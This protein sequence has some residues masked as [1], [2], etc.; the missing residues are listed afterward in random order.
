MRT[1]IFVLG[2]SR[3]GTSLLTR[4]LSMS[5]AAL[6]RNLLGANASNPTG[7]WEPQEAIEIN[8]RYLGGCNSSWLDPGLHL[9]LEGPPS[10]EWGERFE[11]EIAGFLDAEV[12][13]RAPVLVKDPRLPLVLDRWISAAGKR[14]IDCRAVL[15]H[16]HPEEVAA[17]L[18]SRNGIERQH[19]YLLWLKSNLLAERYSREMV[20]SFVTYET[21]WHDWRSALGTAIDR[22]GLPLACPDDAAVKAFLSPDLRHHR[23]TKEPSAIGIEKDWIERLLFLLKAA[24]EGSVAPSEFD[25]LFDQ[26]SRWSTARDARISRGMAPMVPWLVRASGINRLARGLYD[27]KRWMP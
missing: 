7:H 12:S 11:R 19:A 10:Q 14:G 27:P 17:S 26:F 1:I 18:A 23:A 20:R 25:L 16:R 22:L 21:L 5:G 4:L 8:D 3:S 9:Q 15:I 24:I 2:M 13:G 6:P